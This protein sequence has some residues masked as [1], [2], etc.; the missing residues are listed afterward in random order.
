MPPI[1]H[2]HPR[3]L[4]RAL[5]RAL[6]AARADPDAA[7]GLVDRWVEAVRRRQ[8]VRDEWRYLAALD[9]RRLTRA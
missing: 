6:P 7:D 8:R 4:T 2:D 1:V 9:A 3:E 5:T